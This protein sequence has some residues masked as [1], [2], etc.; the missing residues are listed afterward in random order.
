LTDANGCTDTDAIFVE[1]LPIPLQ[2]VIPSAFTPNEDGYNDFF[3]I[4]GKGFDFV[5]LKVYNR[6]GKKVF[7]GNEI[8]HTWNGRVGF[9]E[10]PLGIYVY[11]LQY[12]P[13]GSEVLKKETG[14]VSLL[15]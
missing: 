2:I 6:W 4:S 12:K 10:Q 1:V 7:E 9:K 11:V 15:R 13:I 5:T 8:N 3:Q 14:F